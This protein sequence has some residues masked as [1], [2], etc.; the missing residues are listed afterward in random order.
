MHNWRHVSSRLVAILTRRFGAQHLEIVEDGVQSAFLHAIESWPTTGEP[1]NPDA[2][3][4]RVAEN[5][6]LGE[7]RKA[8]R[9]RGILNENAS[10]WP[11]ASSET[12]APRFEIRMATEI[13]DDLLRMLFVCC[14][15]AIPVE[16]QLALALKTLC[17]FDVREISARL[18][19]KEATI[20]KRLARA[21][22]RLRDNPPDLAFVASPDRLPAVRTILYL[23]YT[24]GYLSLHDQDA[25]RIEL[26]DEAIRLTTI[27][28][29][30][31]VGRNPETFALLALMHLHSARMS[32][33]QDPSGGLL[34]LEEQDRTRWDHRQIATGLEW[35]AR[36]AEGDQ[37]SR[38]HAEAGIAAEHC[39][40]PS[41]QDTR[42][43]RIVE[44]YEL[45][46]SIA[47]SAI[48]RLN[49]AVAVAE[50]EGPRRALDLLA[51]Q[52]PPTWLEGSFQWS[53][54]L[55]DLH[56]RA[57]QPDEAATFRKMAIAAAPSGPIREALER[58]LRVG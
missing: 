34:L 55:A 9:R 50:L 33:R 53:A 29:D 15:D 40:A 20:Y 51:Q 57:G 31:P 8:S 52:K 56:N 36:S 19:T 39:L 7:I 17:G 35:L 14:D 16:S 22:T 49:R 11:I 10:D 44:N 43:D 21:R 3:L 26:C 47:P 2:W 27:L 58:R 38:F 23:I 4:Y 28:A 30:H 45:L 24:E 6:I 32:S 48:H 25:I 46:E 1:E 41:Y 5:N 54:V 37:F 42:W 18:F 13:D 12:E